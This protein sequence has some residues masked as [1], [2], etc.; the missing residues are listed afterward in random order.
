MRV[1][2]LGADSSSGA[3][4]ARQLAHDGFSV[5]C[6][7]DD[8]KHREEL[9]AGVEVR[10][11]SLKDL[12]AVASALDGVQGVHASLSLD[13]NAGERGWQPEGQGLMSMLPLLKERGIRLTYLSSVMVY[14]LSGL[15]FKWW[16]IEMKARTNAAIQASGVKHS[17]FYVA[18]MMEMFLE[19]PFR[20]GEKFGIIGQGD[21]KAYWIASDDVGRMVAKAFTL[22]DRAGAEYFAQGPEYLTIAEAA[23]IFAQHYRRLKLDVVRYPQGMLKAISMV[24]KRAKYALKFLEAMEA[25]EP[26]FLAEQTWQELGK[27][28]TTLIEFAARS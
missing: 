24:N 5:R 8:L 23:E 16:P 7:V 22:G 6:W 18:T 2:V 4:V 21:R 19:P 14:Q 10:T 20:Q 17:I 3:A 25:T 26:R 9:P 11:G 28:S 13:P 15:G 1:L 27:P 12:A